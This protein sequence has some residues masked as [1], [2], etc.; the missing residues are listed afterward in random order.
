[1]TGAGQQA[2]SG[3]ASAWGSI[4]LIC[5]CATAVCLWSILGVCC[6]EEGN[7]VEGAIWLIF[8]GLDLTALTMMGVGMLKQA[9]QPTC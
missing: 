9:R 8:A 5:A 3:G 2:S 7:F 1:M 6:F 4:P